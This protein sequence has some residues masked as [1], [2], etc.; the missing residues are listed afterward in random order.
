MKTFVALLT[1]GTRP[2][3]NRIAFRRSVA[4]QAEGQ[5]VRPIRFFAVLLSALSALPV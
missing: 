5:A 4:S 3:S 1:V 2:V